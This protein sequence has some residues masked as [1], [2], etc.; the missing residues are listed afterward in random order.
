MGVARSQI[1]YCAT[2]SK[3]IEIVVCR[4]GFESPARSR[5]PAI[6]AIPEEVVISPHLQ[7]SRGGPAIRIGENV[8][9]VGVDIIRIA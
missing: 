4:S 3:P 9:R 1:D 2:E 6:R 8:D 5:A 7:G